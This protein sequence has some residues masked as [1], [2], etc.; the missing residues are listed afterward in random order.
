MSSTKAVAA[1]DAFKLLLIK[2]TAAEE[3]E[4]MERFFIEVRKFSSGTVERW[5]SGKQFPIGENLIT[6]AAYLTMRGFTVEEFEKIPERYRTVAK[7]IAL[8]LLPSKALA[9]RLGFDDVS[10]IWRAFRGRA[11]GKNREATVQGL[12]EQYASDVDRLWQA[13][14]ADQS[15]IVSLGKPAGNLQ[16]AVV[17]SLALMMNS[18]LHLVRH[19]NS[20]EFTEEQRQQLR[21]AAGSGTVFDLSNELNDLCSERSREIGKRGGGNGR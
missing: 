8:G 18:M 7:A 14:S 20:D 16:G 15:S 17:Q 4:R 11:M 3:R 9:A 10:D 13:Y 5:V 19:V 1:A 6:V 21:D 2:A 12:T